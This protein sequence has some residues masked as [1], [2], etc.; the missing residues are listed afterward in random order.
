MQAEAFTSACVVYLVLASLN[1]LLIANK[2]RDYCRHCRV[3][4]DHVE[5]STVVRVGEGE[6][7]G[8]H[9]HDHRLRIADK[10][11]AILTQCLRRVDIARSHFAVRV[12]DEPRDGEFLFP[13][14]DH[15]QGAVGTMRGLLYY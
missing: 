14:V 9:A 1:R 7:V 3:E 2:V 13:S 6:A 12:S 8:G 4:A 5:H 10:L 11:A 15:Q